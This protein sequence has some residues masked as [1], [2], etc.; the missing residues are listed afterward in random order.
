MQRLINALR[1][2]NLLNMIILCEQLKKLKFEAVRLAR[3]EL[4]TYKCL[5]L[6]VVFKINIKNLIL[7]VISV[8]IVGI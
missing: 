7:L 4:L 8:M 1:C 5:W 6:W 2:N 3:R